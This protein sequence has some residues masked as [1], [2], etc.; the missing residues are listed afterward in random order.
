M[1]A[2]LRRPVLSEAV[3]K[4]IQRYILEKKLKPGDSLPP[5]AQ[6][7]A[8][9]GVGRSSIRE[10]MKS[11]QSLGIVR[12]QRGEGFFVRKWNLDPVLETLSYG[13]CFNPAAFRELLQIRIW[14]ESATIGE[15]VERITPDDIAQLDAIMQAW[16]ARAN[17]NAGFAD[18]DEQ[19]HNVLYQ[20]LENDTFVSLLRVFWRAF[21]TVNDD[22]GG[23]VSLGIE[24]EAHYA[25]FEAIKRRD[26]VLAREKL[27]A[28]FMNLTDRLHGAPGEPE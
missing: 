12:V 15:V 5:E 2:N 21:E 28:S 8:D 3:R 17:S 19:F 4:H 9:L 16:K 6:L 22:L 18:L 7:A 26:P 27:L 10:A 23:D 24:Y 20:S 25:I 11:L 13:I 14:L 1:D